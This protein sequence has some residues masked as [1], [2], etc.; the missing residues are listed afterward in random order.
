MSLINKDT[1]IQKEMNS[2]TNF[3]KNTLIKK[4]LQDLPKQNIDKIKNNLFFF[5]NFK[6]SKFNFLNFN[7]KEF[8]EHLKTEP[9]PSIKS[10]LNNNENDISLSTNTN[11][12]V[13]NDLKENNSELTFP[14]SKKKYL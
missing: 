4:I 1:D 5:Q 9:I 3:E 11:S 14:S 8:K 13:L 2:I 12:T 6:D 7:N 10:N